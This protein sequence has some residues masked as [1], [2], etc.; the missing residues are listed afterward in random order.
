MMKKTYIRPEAKAL[1]MN[2][3]QMIAT[4]LE[5]DDANTVRGNEVLT[6]RRDY[7]GTAPWNEEE[8]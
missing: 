2:M 7:W 8:E 3:E 6:N 4:S 1:A 5:M